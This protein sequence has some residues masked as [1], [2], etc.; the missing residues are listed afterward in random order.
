MMDMLQWARRRAPTGRWT[1]PA[2]V[3]RRRSAS[4]G[5]S[6][7]ADGQVQRVAGV[8]RDRRGSMGPSTR[9]DGQKPELD[10]GARAGRASMGPST[11]ADGQDVRQL[12]ARGLSVDAR[13]RTAS[14]SART[15]YGFSCLNEAIDVRRRTAWARLAR[16]GALGKLQWT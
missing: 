13:R 7:R 3:P 6:T 8:H 11:R 10:R 4:M 15:W 2:A 16:G 1:H 5:P 12:R 9:A 14:I